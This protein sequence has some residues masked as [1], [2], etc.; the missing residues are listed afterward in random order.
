MIATV[1]QMVHSTSKLHNVPNS[2]VGASLN[3]MSPGCNH[4][5]G[6]CCNMETMS[7]ERFHHMI[8]RILWLT[9]SGLVSGPRPMHLQRKF[10]G[11]LNWLG[12]YFGSSP[13]FG[14]CSWE[15]LPTGFQRFRETYG[16]LDLDEADIGG[17]GWYTEDPQEV[18]LL[19][20]IH[21][22]GAFGRVKHLM[23]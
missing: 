19:N 3:W 5:S 1:G 20:T 10:N 17:T 11:F 22:M 13:R 4:I 16:K 2:G 21:M 18:S 12:G 15:L 9:S 23:R 14:G 6:S 7:G 8:L